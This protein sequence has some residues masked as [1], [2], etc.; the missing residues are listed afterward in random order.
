MAG[1]F[2]FCDF[3]HGLERS[4]SKG[5]PPLLRLF[6]R[7]GKGNIYYVAHGKNA[8]YLADN[9]FHTREVIKFLGNKPKLAGI[10]L[11]TQRVGTI[12]KEILIEKKWN[13]ELWKRKTP[14]SDDWILDKKASPGNLSGLGHLLPKDDQLNVGFDSAAVMAVKITACNQEMTF[15]VAFCDTTLCVLDIIEFIDK[16][17]F[18]MLESIL[19]QR[20]AKECLVGIDNNVLSKSQKKKLVRVFEKCGVPVKQRPTIEFLTK[21]IVQDLGMLV[22]SLDHHSNKI[23]KTHAMGALACLINHL[24]LLRG[25]IGFGGFK[26]KLLDF[27]AFMKLDKATMEALNLFPKVTD[28]NKNLTLFGLLNKC[29]T[30]MGSRLLMQWIKQPLMDIV[31]IKRRHNLVEIFVQDTQLRQSLRENH[32]RKVPDIDRMAKK[33]QQSKATLQ[34]VV[35]LYKFTIRL[36]KLVDAL[37]CYDGS[38]CELIKNDFIRKFQII[39]A[40]FSQFEAMIEQTVDL[41]RVDKNEYLINPKFNPRLLEIQQYREHLDMEFDTHIKDAARLLSLVLK[42]VKTCET[43][44][45]GIHLRISRK[46]ERNLRKF[47]TPKSSKRSFIHLSTLK[48]GVHFTTPAIKKIAQE[49]INLKDEY[50]H[51]QKEIVDKALEICM[52]YTP[53]M[54][55]LTETLSELDVLVCFGHIAVSASTPYCRPNVTPMDDNVIDFRESRHPTL[56]TLEGISFIPN[57]IQLIRGK[58]NVQLITG[59]NMGGKSTYIRQIGLITVMA[60]IGSFVP[61]S[62]A[63]LPIVDCI[64]TRVGAVDSQL[65]GISTFMKEML[66]ASSILKTASKHSLIIIDELGRGTSTYDGFGL[67]WAISEYIAC[68]IQAFTLCATHFHELT[69]LAAQENVGVINMHVTAH[70]DKDT[71]TM[72]YKVQPGPCDRSF[73][74]HVAEL[75]KFPKSVIEMAN[76]KAIELE[77]FEIKAAKI[78]GDK[79]KFNQEEKNGELKTNLPKRQRTANLPILTTDEKNSLNIFLDDFVGIDF[80]GNDFNDKLILLKQKVNSNPILEKCL[81]SL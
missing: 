6:E 61:C 40:D 10:N 42:K 60:Q 5:Q 55:Q 68:E 18:T 20:G 80:N 50:N 4:E 31:Q 71:I 12:L 78:S 67:A 13:V 28:Q 19:I 81:R 34:D 24:E 43:A 17:T 62:S 1:K 11:S 33:F 16:D 23:E 44:E 51:I 9:Y 45:Y 48:D 27:S 36:P 59:P 21:D 30:T 63:T 7:N 32:I 26:L 37:Q 54:D 64:L 39:S 70:T 35:N 73:G 56:E 8:I 22:G 52:S 46:D 77:S 72:L 29:K 15:G 53:V 66:E 2:G 3:Y 74:I 49:K 58:S 47:L 41:D 38:N 75:A 79:R 65:K 76:E 25:D 57:D 14:R 69:E